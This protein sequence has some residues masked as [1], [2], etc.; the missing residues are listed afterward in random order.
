ML[1]VST[2]YIRIHTLSR[3]FLSGGT[4]RETRDTVN[5]TLV[6]SFLIR[7]EV[8][9]LPKIASQCKHLS[10]NFK[11]LMR[12]QWMLNGDMGHLLFHVLNYLFLSTISVLSV[13]E[14]SHICF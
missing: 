2:S 10:L 4:E 6:Q 13:S 12:H 14:L 3:A 7:F 5:N 1:R 11:L 9:L 8:L